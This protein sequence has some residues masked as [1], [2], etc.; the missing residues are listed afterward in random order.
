[1]ADWVAK[2]AIKKAWKAYGPRYTATVTTAAV[3][4]DPKDVD[5]L[6]DL[7]ISAHN[8]A[9][10]ALPPDAQVVFHEVLEIDALETLATTVERTRDGVMGDV[11]VTS[12]MRSFMPAFNLALATIAEHRTDLGVTSDVEAVGWAF[13]YGAANANG[14]HSLIL[15]P[16]M[17][18]VLQA[19]QYHTGK[20]VADR[21]G[22]AVDDLRAWLNSDRAMD[23]LAVRDRLARYGVV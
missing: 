10:R 13:S 1:M 11:M 21:T 12:W 8:E 5:A 3:G 18:R 19:A 15:R 20:R 6:T 2:R 7:H 23:G 22:I 16:M 4:I 14:D 17:E 9:L